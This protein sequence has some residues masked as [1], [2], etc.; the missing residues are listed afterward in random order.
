VTSRCRQ[1]AGWAAL[2]F[3]AASAAAAHDGPPYPIVSDE[4]LGAYEVSVWTDPDTT[5]DETLGGQFWII[6]RPVAGGDVPPGTRVALSARAAEPGLAEQ[7]ATGTAE[8]R[9]PSRY[10]AAVRFARE[11]RW[12]VGV[13]I[14]GP[15]GVASTSAEV[16][17]TYDL[18]P[19]PALL[20]VYVLPFLLVG[21]LWI[22]ALRRGRTRVR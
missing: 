9:N 7:R 2:L 21:F 18:R 5:D 12:H 11:G 20:L 10:F 13:T 1:T 19:A 4:R 6:V 3:A 15:L 14:D 17:A 8:P 16:E 22:K